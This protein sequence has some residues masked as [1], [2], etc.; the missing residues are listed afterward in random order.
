MVNDVHHT[1]L[2]ITQ[3]K[4]E[5]TVRNPSNKNVYLLVRESRLKAI[6][7]NMTE[8]SSE[9]RTFTI[10]EIVQQRKRNEREGDKFLGVGKFYSW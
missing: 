1:F 8:I 7:F 4:Y 5:T 6:Y 3:N 2:K 10:I 9:K